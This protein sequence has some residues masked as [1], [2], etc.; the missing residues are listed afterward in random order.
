MLGAGKIITS[1]HG[2]VFHR[3]II[4]QERFDLSQFHAKTADFNLLVNTAY[5]YH[6]AVRLIAHQVA[7][8]VEA[9]R[10]GERIGDKTLLI[11]FRPVVV[12]Q[13]Q[14]VAAQQQ[15]AGNAHGNRLVMFIHDIV[16]GISD[17]FTDGN[18]DRIFGDFLYCIPGGEGGVFR[19]SVAIQ[20][21]PGRGTVEHFFESVHIGGVPAGHEII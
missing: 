13:G 7:R 17:G 1:D 10:F 5:E 15:L 14:A 4:P 3:G 19:G 9:P 21:M 12:A 16:I 20:E 2:A 6:I 18:R 11:E 8:P